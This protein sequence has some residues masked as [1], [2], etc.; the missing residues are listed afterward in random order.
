M[1]E[2]FTHMVF[3]VNDY[4]VNLIPPSSG[5]VGGDDWAFSVSIY[6]VYPA[7]EL[8]PRA[9]G[10]LP[11]VPILTPAHDDYVQTSDSTGPAQALSAP[12]SQQVFSP[13]VYFYLPENDRDFQE[14]GGIA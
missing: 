13:V 14:G 5:V 1:A 9:M 4:L 11:V 7:S 8:I 10:L 2:H 6:A 3:S 12:P